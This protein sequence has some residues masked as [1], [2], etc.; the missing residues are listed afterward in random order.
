MDEMAGIMQKH[1][2]CRGPNMMASLLYIY[3]LAVGSTTRKTYYHR[4][5]A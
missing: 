3:S 5:F 1:V 4:I 2:I